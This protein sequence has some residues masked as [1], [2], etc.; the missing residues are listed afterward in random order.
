M[1]SKESSKIVLDHSDDI[2]VNI[3]FKIKIPHYLG[4]N[5]NVEFIVTKSIRRHPA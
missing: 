5:C 4:Y 3:Y 2:A 1:C